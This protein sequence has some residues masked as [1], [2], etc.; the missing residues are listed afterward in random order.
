MQQQPFPQSGLCVQK[1]CAFF[2]RH[3]SPPLFLACLPHGNGIFQRIGCTILIPPEGPVKDRR[4]QHGTVSVFPREADLR[5]LATL[6]LGRPDGGEQ[7][8]PADAPATVLEAGGP[9]ADEALAAAE[10]RA[11]A[12]ILAPRG[13]TGTG[14]AA[15]GLETQDEDA[16]ED[17]SVAGAQHDVLLAAGVV[18]FKPGPGDVLG[19]GDVAGGAVP[20]SKEVRHGDAASKQN[21]AAGVT[22]RLGQ[23]CAAVDEA[24]GG[25]QCGEAQRV[26]GQGAGGARLHLGEGVGDEA[27]ALGLVVAGAEGVEGQR[28][29]VVEGRQGRVR[30]E[31]GGRRGRRGREVGLRRVGLEVGRVGGGGDGGGGEDEVGAEKGEEGSA[32]PEARHD[33]NSIGDEPGAAVAEVQLT[34]AALHDR[35]R[36]YLL[37]PRG[38][39]RRSKSWKTLI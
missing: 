18:G 35:C 14:G 2:K 17:V 32:R 30:G 3:P 22:T 26:E 20:Y 38:V 24:P 12:A 5:V 31:G 7:E 34:H 6:L 21:G 4:Q 9:R 15:L 39:T 19:E 8:V 33:A 1:A 10:A 37:Q 11:A 27:Q 29:D 13:G 36:S 16:D 28:G 23:V 25:G